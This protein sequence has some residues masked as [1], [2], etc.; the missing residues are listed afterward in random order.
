MGA[1]VESWELSADWVGPGAGG[2]G[3]GAVGGMEERIVSSGVPEDCRLGGGALGG[4]GLEVCGAGFIAA[5]V[6]GPSRKVEEG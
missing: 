6:V 2:G 3:G 4:G 1:E 5:R